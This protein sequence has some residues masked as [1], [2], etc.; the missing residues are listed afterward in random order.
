M[1]HIH[2]TKETRIELAAFLHAG[3]N[4]SECGRL[5]GMNRS[6]V[7]REIKLYQD[8]DGTYRGGGAN[9]RALERRKR[10]KVSTQKIENDRKLRRHIVRKLKLF[11]SPE[12]IGDCKIFCVKWNNLTLI[13]LTQPYEKN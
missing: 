12:Q 9:K 6:S 1:S 3:K 7:S 10:A 11:W 5:L 13:H 4:Y 2:F 8:N